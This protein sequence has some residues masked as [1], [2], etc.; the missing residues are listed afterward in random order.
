VTATWYKPRRPP[1]IR[2]PPQFF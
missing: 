1:E 2:R